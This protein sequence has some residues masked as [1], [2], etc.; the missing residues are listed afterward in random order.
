MTGEE[1]TSRGADPNLVVLAAGI[2]SRMRKPASRLPEGHENAFADAL[3]KSKSM[4]GV[5]ENRRPFLDYLLFNAREAGYR[6]AVLVVGER[7]PE[8]RRYYESP[9][10]AKALRPLKISCVVQPI[11]GGR[12]KPL[13]TADAL[14]RALTARPDWR[15]RKL[16]VCNSDN[17]YSSRALRLLLDSPYDCAMIDYDLAGLRLA[18]EKIG[19]FAV[20]RKDG[21][22]YVTAIIEKP[23]PEEVAASA[24]QEGRVGVSMNIFR[25][26][27]DTVAPLL[28]QVPLH[29][30][31]DEK[32]L[33][34]AVAIL[35]RSRPSVLM[36]IPVSEDVPDLTSQ[37]DIPA[38]QDYIRKAYRDF[39]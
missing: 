4:I 20:I 8:I 3:L 31:R 17:L 30:V 16:T 22:G 27:Y 13:G 7:D 26:S 1:R 6:D 14:L 10:T 23:S 34:E 35:I 21:A 9:D 24:D 12:R 29:P 11:P 2:S 25:F 36:A 38:V 33:P 32:E 39:T 15:G 37:D 19:Q 28:E 5:G 18:R